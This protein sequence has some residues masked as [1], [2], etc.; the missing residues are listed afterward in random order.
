M[1]K[2]TQAIEWAAKPQ[3]GGDVGTYVRSRSTS[4]GVHNITA[5]EIAADEDNYRPESMTEAF[6][7]WCQ[8]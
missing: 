4:Y 2:E 5:L 8:C 7:R 1:D 6:D 3:P